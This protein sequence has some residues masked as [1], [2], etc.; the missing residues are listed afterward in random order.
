MSS[1]GR[2]HENEGFG[3]PRK[4]WS[5]LWFFGVTWL[6]MALLIGFITVSVLP[7]FDRLVSDL[8]SVQEKELVRGVELEEA[9]K[10]QVI[11]EAEILF[12]Q[13]ESL[14]LNKQNIDLAKE[15]IETLKKA[16]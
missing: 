13:G 7:R 14:K 10:R 8:K 6:G 1:N 12:L 16:K 9:R 5:A 2:H 11:Q 4:W 15:L 3:I